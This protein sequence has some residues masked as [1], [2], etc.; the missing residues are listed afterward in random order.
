MKVFAL[1]A[2]LALCLTAAG[3]SGQTEDREATA[4]PEGSEAEVTSGSFRGADL[5]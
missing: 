5:L 1:L 4:D 3:C 2:C